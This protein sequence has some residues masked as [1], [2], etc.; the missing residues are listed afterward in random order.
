[1]TNRLITAAIIVIGNEILSGRT[2]DQNV[3]FIA[4][5]LGEA[6]IS[7]SEVRI[8]PDTYNSIITTTK[9]LSASYDYVF[10]TGGIGPTHDDIT[11]SAIAQ[12]FDTEL[13]LNLV[14]LNIMLEFAHKMGKTE[15]SYTNKKMAYIP[16]GTRLIHNPISGAPGFIIKNVYVLPGIPD[17]MQAMFDLIL[18][19][20]EHGP[21]IKSLTIDLNIGESIVAHH[22]EEIQNQH[23]DI[24]IGSYPFMKDNKYAT[25]IVLTSSQHESLESAYNKLIILLADYITEY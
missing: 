19:K 20:L 13:E 24:S 7:L 1:M 9:E 23:L 25:S 6:G 10:T 21:H 2:Q 12:A 11:T 8:V 5:R 4:R 18:P 3:Q 22:L 14:A 16:K 15:V 17:I